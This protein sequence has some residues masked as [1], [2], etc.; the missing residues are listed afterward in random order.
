MIDVNDEYETLV[1]AR[2]LDFFGSRTPWHRSLWTI[3]I[4]LILKELLEVS[5]AVRASILF[6]N[7]VDDISRSAMALTGK[8]PGL[9]DKP[10]R[11]TLQRSLRTDLR[12]LGLDYRV[13]QQVL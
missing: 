6:Q 7:S 12:F 8:D 4:V 9:G 11:V 2:L 1:G 13:V 10:R 5:E 3:G